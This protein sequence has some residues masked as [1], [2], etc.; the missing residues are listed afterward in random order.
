MC[1]CMQFA[2][3]VG[4]LSYKITRSF[5]SERKYFILYP[6]EGICNILSLAF[7][8]CFTYRNWTGERNYILRSNTIRQ[9]TD[10]LFK[11]TVGCAVPTDQEEFA[12]VITYCSSGALA[13][14]RG[15]SWLSLVSPDE[16]WHS[17]SASEL[18]PS[19]TQ[20]LSICRTFC[21]SFYRQP[22]IRCS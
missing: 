12:S 15:V 6:M 13:Q 1:I 16:K 3:S 14:T 9:Y 4:K 8:G 17:M 10:I 18:I 22:N 21:I 20:A 7:S 19:L 5:Q 11:I 2:C